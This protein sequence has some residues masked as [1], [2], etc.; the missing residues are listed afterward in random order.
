MFDL[1]QSFNFSFQTV[2]DKRHIHSRFLFQSACRTSTATTQAASDNTTK[3]ATT[4]YVRTAVANVVDSAPAA[5]DTL[6]ELAAALGDDANYATTTA[7]SIGTKL[8]KSGGQMTGNITMAGSQTVDGRDLS[9]DGAKLDNI[10]SGATADQT[11]SEIAIAL[12][13]Q[14]LGTNSNGVHDVYNDDWFRNNNSG[15][16][17]YNQ[18]TTQHFYSDDDDYWN[19]A[20]G[21]SAN[22]LRFRDDHAGTIRGYVYANNSNQIGFLNRH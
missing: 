11:G 14:T 13:G 2:F 16:G 4:A 21:G 5:L 1:N 22:G 15:E 18:S 8:P 19:I 6:N 3:I 9:V 7:N 10:E 12:R 20:G 17:M